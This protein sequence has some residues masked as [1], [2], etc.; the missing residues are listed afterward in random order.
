M[1]AAFALLCLA[2]MTIEAEDHGMRERE[3]DSR[4]I[5]RG[6]VMNVGRFYLLAFLGGK[7]NN[8][9]FA[10]LWWVVAS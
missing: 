3:R 7:Y 6:I 2:L 10:Q 9:D 5:Y 1:A 4:K 8:F